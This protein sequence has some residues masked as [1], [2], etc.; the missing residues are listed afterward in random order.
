M[1][2]STLCFQ[3]RM[4]APP[5]LEA[6]TISWR[7]IIDPIGVHPMPHN[8]PAG[9]A[10]GHFERLTLSSSCST[11]DIGQA[12]RKRSCP[13]GKHQSDAIQNLV[14]SKPVVESF[15]QSM[16]GHIDQFPTLKLAP[17][18]RIR[19][20]HTRHFSSSTG[21]ACLYRNPGP[22]NGHGVFQRA[23][24]LGAQ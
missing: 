12:I 18:D 7:H 21:V 23:Q 1:L 17:K 15:A 22:Q 16:Q 6:V 9:S 24:Y 11:C 8:I 4:T 5:R 20:L 13:R 3:A 2:P 10:Y 19:V 14:S